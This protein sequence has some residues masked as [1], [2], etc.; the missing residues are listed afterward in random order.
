MYKKEPSIWLHKGSQ[1]GGKI[2]SAMVPCPMNLVERPSG[3]RSLRGQLSVNGQ[4]WSLPVQKVSA[5]LSEFVRKHRA[6]QACTGCVVVFLVYVF[7]GGFQ[8]K[9][10]HGHFGAGP[11][12]SGQTWPTQSRS[13]RPGGLEG[14][15]P[16]RRAGRV[17][18]A[19]VHQP[20][21]PG[22]EGRPLRDP[23]AGGLAG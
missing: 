22:D 23:G 19:L 1:V 11:L 12:F 13:A 2:R 10:V 18:V 21:V 5:S 3:S 8:E 6:L 17:G 9:G 16:A 20:G 14:G 7:S 15:V 4:H